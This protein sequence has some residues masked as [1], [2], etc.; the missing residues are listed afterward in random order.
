MEST[1]M[2][3]ING[4]KSCQMTL[5]CNFW[6]MMIKKASGFDELC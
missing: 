1:F 6:C 4:K 5:N 3:N 2:T